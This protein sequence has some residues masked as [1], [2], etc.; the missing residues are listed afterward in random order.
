MS[1]EIKGKLIQKMAVESGDGRNG[2]WEK[3]QF[4]IETEEQFPK[5]VCIHVWND[6]LPILEGIVEGDRIN[7]HI[8]IAS[9]EYN[10][11][12]YTDITA[13]RIERDADEGSAPPLPDGPP[14]DLDTRED[15]LP[16]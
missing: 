16:F 10:S 12:W 3:Q 4:V 2:K 6:K 11:K 9:R 13:W 14:L 1:L 7:V 15:D 8:N 5:K